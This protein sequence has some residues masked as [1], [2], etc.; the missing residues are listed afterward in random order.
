MM[1]KKVIAIDFDGVLHESSSPWTKAAEVN[2]GP[3]PG[4]LEAVRSYLAAGYRVVVYSARATDPKGRAA[5]LRW[6]SSHQFPPMSVTHE[7]PNAELYIDDRGF[8]FTGNNWPSVGYLKSFRPWNKRE[9]PPE[10]L[11]YY[12]CNVYAECFHIT[13]PDEA[14]LERLGY[15]TDLPLPSIVTVHRYA[16]RKVREV[17]INE[18]AQYCLDTVIDHLDDEYGC[19][20]EGSCGTAEMK[21]ILVEAVRKVVERYKVWTCE[22][23]L[24]PLI[25][26]VAAWIRKH[27]PQW[28]EEEKI[29]TE[30]ERL[31]AEDPITSLNTGAEDIVDLEL[32]KVDNII[33]IGGM[34]A[35]LTERAARFVVERWEGIPARIAAGRTLG[36]GDA[37]AKRV[38]SDLRTLCGGEEMYTECKA[39]LAELDRKPQDG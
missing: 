8:Q 14:V 23:L 2:D 6:L 38:E 21:A 9:K 3:T 26:P 19:P 33:A 18:E 10:N 36:W 4:A 11:I 17:D 12:S 22:E 24:P 37:V 39:Y 30:V 32:K 5:I 31:E 29:R 7:K 34:G 1:Y 28:L 15:I 20:D 13:D 35:E 27:Q 25:V 16:P